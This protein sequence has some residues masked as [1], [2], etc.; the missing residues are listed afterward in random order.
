M[1]EEA[2]SFTC[3]T[4]RLMTLRARGIAAAPAAAPAAAATATRR[5]RVFAAFLPAAERFGDFRALDAFFAAPA[6]RADPE[7]RFFEDFFDDLAELP[8]DDEDLFFELF[9]ELFREPLLE[10]LLLELRFFEDFLEDFFEDFFE[11][12][13]DAIGSLLF[14]RRW[15]RRDL[16]S[17]V[18][19]VC[20]I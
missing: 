1:I 15:G 6:R 20:N 5:V 19:G 18:T 13:F 12:F 3:S 14:K 4:T 8:R 17:E 2:V 10:L 16:N 9:F 7:E 11:P